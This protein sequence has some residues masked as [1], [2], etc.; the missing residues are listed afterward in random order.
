MR[1]GGVNTWGPLAGKNFSRR[2]LPP[3]YTEL[4]DAIMAAGRAERISFGATV[5]KLNMYNT[6]AHTTAVASSTCVAPALQDMAFEG[7]L[8]LNC[9]ARSMHCVNQFLLSSLLG[10][11]D[12]FEDDDEEQARCLL[13]EKVDSSQQLYGVFAKLE[14]RGRQAWY[15]SYKVGNAQLQGP[16]SRVEFVM[17]LQGKS[18]EELD[19]DDEHQVLNRL[20]TVAPCLINVFTYVG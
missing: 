14:E 12:F 4:G 2:T 9:E 11:Y 8:A 18:H 6:A 20:L 3:L 10:G 1:V 7:Y 15:Q 16:G 19:E 17:S 5:T 13:D